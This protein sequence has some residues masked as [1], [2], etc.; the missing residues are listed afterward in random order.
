MTETFGLIAIN[1]AQQPTLLKC[2]DNTQGSKS[3]WKCLV[4]ERASEVRIT[5]ATSA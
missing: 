1:K 2:L 3:N 4:E 5:P